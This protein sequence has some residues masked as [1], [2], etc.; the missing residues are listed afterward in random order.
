LWSCAGLSV[1]T[2]IGLPVSR[3]EITKNNIGETNV[4]IGGGFFA[5]VE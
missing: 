3:A 5:V 2:S 1:V 4:R